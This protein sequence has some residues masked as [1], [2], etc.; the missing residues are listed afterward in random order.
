MENEQKLRSIASS[1]KP[2]ASLEE[3]LLLKQRNPQEFAKLPAS[4]RISVGHYLNAK[5]A[6]QQLAKMEEQHAN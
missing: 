6:H 1:Y 5:S 4:K 2:N 3:L